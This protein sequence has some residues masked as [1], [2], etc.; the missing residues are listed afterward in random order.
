MRWLEHLTPDKTEVI[1]V[2]D[3]STDNS[4]EICD[5]FA[6]QYQGIVRVI[7]QANAGPSAARNAGIEAAHGKWITF[8]DADDI[9]AENYSQCLDMT[10]D[11]ADLHV[12]AIDIKQNG[13]IQHVEYSDGLYI[14]NDIATYL[15]DYV[16]AA[17][18]GNGWN[19]NKI[20]RRELI[21]DLRFDPDC[22]MMEDEIFNQQ[23][24][25]RSK[26]VKCHKESYYTYLIDNPCG[27]HNSLQPNYWGIINTV[28]QNFNALTVKFSNKN[29]TLDLALLK[30][31]C[32]P[33][34][35]CVEAG[36]IAGIK[37]S[38]A[39]HFLKRKAK[40]IWWKDRVYLALVELD[41]NWL[42]KFFRILLKGWH[43]RYL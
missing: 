36:L 9:V 41:I 21:G 11:N 22:R 2:N 39:F 5:L 3:G 37:D 42:T 18:P 12:F 40:Y 6:V 1:L 26:S 33:F 24:L 13:N 43:T 27:L 35:R 4:G 8:L 16:I 31:T 32:R 20:Y 28:Y 15:A 17:T 25:A 34:R 29:A 23:Y 14:G 10:C 30:R 19:V 38:E 7:H